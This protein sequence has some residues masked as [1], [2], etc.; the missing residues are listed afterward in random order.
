VRISLLCK[1]KSRRAET[2]MALVVVAERP[3]LVI[4][5]AA[6][7][8]ELSFSTNRMRRDKRKPSCGRMIDIDCRA[9]A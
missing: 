1:I 4:A 3:G 7:K 5:K 9:E 8:W 6:V 2:L